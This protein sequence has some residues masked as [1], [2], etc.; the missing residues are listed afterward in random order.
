MNEV[1]KKRR[2]SNNS[3][4]LLNSPAEYDGV[5]LV[6]QKK[7]KVIF[8]VKKRDRDD[9]KLTIYKRKSKSGANSSD[10]TGHQK[11]GSALS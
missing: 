3:N 9:S 10:D 11:P 7:S 1:S 4:T 6:D 2:E 8:S 5:S